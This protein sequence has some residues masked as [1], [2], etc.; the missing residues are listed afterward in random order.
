VPFNR[1]YCVVA[2]IGLPGRIPVRAKGILERSGLSLVQFER[3]GRALQALNDS[4]QVDAFVLDG[5]CAVD[6]QEEQLVEALIAL[7]ADPPWCELPL[8]VILLT[9]RRM[10]VRLRRSCKTSGVHRIGRDRLGYRRVSRLILTLCDVEGT[11]IESPVNA[12]GIRS[13]DA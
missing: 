3:P 7:A 12:G 13:I 6:E 10:P 1:P 11:R 8:P 5:A 4:L 2:V 9:S